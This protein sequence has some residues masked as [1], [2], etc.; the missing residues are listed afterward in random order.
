M[1]RRAAPVLALAAAWCA[2]TVLGA[3]LDRPSDDVALLVVALV[4]LPLATGIVLALAL[5][6]HDQHRC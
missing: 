3:H 5:G 1:A 6:F 4:A 2:W